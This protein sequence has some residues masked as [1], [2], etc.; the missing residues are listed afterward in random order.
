MIVF[1]RKEQADWLWAKLLDE[2]Y[3]SAIMM[4]TDGPDTPPIEDYPEHRNLENAVLAYAAM[5][6][7]RD[8]QP[9]VSRDARDMPFGSAPNREPGDMER[10]TYAA[11]REAGVDPIRGLFGEDPRAI[12]PNCAHGVPFDEPCNICASADVRPDDE[13]NPPKDEALLLVGGVPVLLP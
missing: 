6:D 10:E 1:L 3:D 13:V 4:R 12:A 2:I 7:A 9:R 11:A 8:N 5:I